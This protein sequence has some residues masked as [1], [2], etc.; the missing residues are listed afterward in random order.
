MAKLSRIRKLKTS[1]S[2]AALRLSK[3]PCSNK[4]QQ[5]IKKQLMGN[6]LNIRS[7]RAKSQMRMGIKLYQQQNPQQAIRQWKAAKR[8]LKTCEDKFL[9]SGYIVQAYC[10]SGDYDQMLQAAIE[11]V[12]LANNQNDDLMRS[13]A[14]LNLARANERL[15][16]Y[17]RAI[18]FA[19]Q[20]LSLPGIDKRSPGYAH[21]VIAMAR[22]GI[23]GLQQS[24]SHFELS[25]KIAIETGDK[26]LELQI[27]LGLGALF[28]LLRD[29]N[30]ALIFLQNALGIMHGIEANHVHA[31]YRS[32]ILY[33]LS[34]I[35]RLKGRLSEARQVCE[36]SIHLAKQ[37]G[38]KP[39]FAR[40]LASLADIFCEIGETEARETVTKSWARYEQAFR[41]LRKINDRSG[42]I[43]VLASMARSASENKGVHYAGRC[44][45]QAIQLNKKCLELATI[46]GSKH[47]MMECHSRLYDLYNQLSD[48]E[49]SAE[50]NRQQRHLIQQ[51]ELFCNF[52]G[53][54][55][56][57]IEESLQ[58]LNCSHIFHEKCLQKYLL[59]NGNEPY[60]CPKCKLGTSLMENI[61]ISSSTAQTPVD[62]SDFICS[63]I[64]STSTAFLRSS[65]TTNINPP[66]VILCERNFEENN[67]NWSTPT[68]ILVENPK[69]Q[70]NISTSTNCSFTVPTIIKQ[71]ELQN[72]TKNIHIRRKSVPIELNVVNNGEKEEEEELIDLKKIKDIPINKIDQNIIKITEENLQLQQNNILITKTTTNGSG[73]SKRILLIKSSKT[74]ISPVVEENEEEEE[75]EEKEGK[76]KLSSR[77]VTEL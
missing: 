41:L 21:L 63:N 49:N 45:C 15:A 27:S 50:S 43:I 35:L 16:E 39:T 42:Q 38:N 28:T 25:M 75:E 51:M 13:E 19:E 32:A 8:K 3:R 70:I 73:R 4:H 1:S 12:E 77:G 26:L 20:S 69:C 74:A 44:E 11:Q 64:P 30:K 54:R 18:N 23:S 53:Q 37:V 9:T 5:L 57:E 65:T 55:Y 71:Q 48:Q 10:D 14:L 33:Q 46:I 2:T 17:E 52:C 24:L 72:K 66:P 31:K 22:M 60:T 58:A 59:I 56:G 62:N 61:S 76:Q 7:K 34:V 6:V 36:E 67:I 47:A 40:A 68:N 29:L